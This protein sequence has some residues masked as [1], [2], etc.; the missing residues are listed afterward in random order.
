M[1]FFQ[2][3][4]GVRAVHLSV[5]ELKGDGECRLKPAFTVT[6]PSQKGVVVDAAVLIDYAVEFRP[7]H[8]R[9]AYD[10]GLIVKDVLTSLAD[11]LCQM[12]VIGVK[13]LQIIADGNVAETE[14][15]LQ[16]SSMLNF[17]PRRRL[18]LQ[19]LVTSKVLVSV[20]IGMGD[21]VHSS[22][23]M[24]LLVSLG[25]ISCFIVYLFSTA[26]LQIVAEYSK[27]LGYSEA[28]CDEWH[29]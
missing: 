24:A 26:K 3:P 2:K 1:Q 21:F 29:H 27:F 22:K 25:L 10:D 16:Q 28:I 12:H 5:V 7:G 14:S 9:C 23:A 4:G 17:I 13:R 8:C 19:S 20:T 18:T 15:A 11:G 6:A